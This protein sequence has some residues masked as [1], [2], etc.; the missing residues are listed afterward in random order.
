MASNPAARTRRGRR[1]AIGSWMA[2]VVAT[3]TP[4]QTA[5]VNGRRII[6]TVPRSRMVARR[7]VNSS[8]WWLIRAY[9]SQSVAENNIS[10]RDRSALLERILYRPPLGTPTV[11]VHKWLHPLDV[12]L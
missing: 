9:I 3:A 10:G 8:S 6:R 5:N 12:M 11:E 1:A 2:A 7:A 4:P